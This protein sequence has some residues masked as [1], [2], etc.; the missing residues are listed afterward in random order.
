MPSAEG[1]AETAIDEDRFQAFLVECEGD[2]GWLKEY[3][4][5]NWK[6][7]RES[8]NPNRR[9]ENWRFGDPR[10]LTPGKC[11]TTTEAVAEGSIQRLRESSSILPSANARIILVN[12]Q[13]IEEANL[14]ND[15]REKG[16]IFES[17]ETAISKHSEKVRVHLADEQL[18]LG[19]SKQRAL[20]AAFLKN[21]AYLRIPS[22]IVINEPLMIYHWLNG[23]DTAIFPRTIIEA[24]ENSEATVENWE[25]RTEGE[26]QNTFLRTFSTGI[27]SL[28][29][30]AKSLSTL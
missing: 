11:C 17:L 7:Y 16:V 21:G 5:A 19:S 29:K 20:H 4:Q 14:P 6:L 10:R 25:A 8:P 23:E 27:S 1:N 2:P 24:E 30:K 26:S 22:G 3:R 9:E 18:G 28:I 13:C 15:L 12:D